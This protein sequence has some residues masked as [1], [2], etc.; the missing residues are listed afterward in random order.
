VKTRDDVYGLLNEFEKQFG[1]PVV[2]A[3]Q[4]SAVWFQLKLGVISA[5]NASKAVAKVGTDTRMTYM[6]E[7]AAQVCTGVMEEISSKYMDWG[8]QHEDAAR[9]AY[10]F[11]TGLTV[12]NLPFVYKDN[13]FRE[14]CSPD[15]IV[16]KD[17]GIEIKCPF[18]SVN[19]VK[20]LAED[21]IKPEYD[22]QYQY[23]MRIMDADEWDFMQYD[24]RMKTL[25]YKVV[26]AKRD[27][28]KQKVF[29]DAIPQFIEDMDKMLKKLGV[30]FGDQWKRLGKGA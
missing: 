28:E 8:N 16:T 17:K 22:W 27:A 15:G 18:N 29:D 3:Q 25:P 19:F 21:K 13:K 11:E 20:F 6:S 2:D 24:P 5:S 1:F 12:T 4:K 9:S 7:L 10:E 26:T 23:T 14:G 30:T